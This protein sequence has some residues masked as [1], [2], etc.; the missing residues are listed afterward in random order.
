[1]SIPKV[2]IIIPVYKVEEYIE[3]C[4]RSLFSQTLDELEYIF[5]DD[6]GNDNSFNVIDKIIDEFPHR[7]SQVRIIRNEVNRGVGQTRRH[8][9]DVASGEY[10]IHCD[11]DDRVD[12]DMYQTLYEKAKLNDADVCICDY[13]VDNSAGETVV[14]QNA[15]SDKKALFH[16]L[17][18]ETL[19]AALWNKMVRSDLAKRFPIETGIN[20]W[21]DLSV[22][23]LILL[24]ANRIAKV[25]RP[26][27]HYNMA[28]SGSVSH[29]DYAKNVVSSVNAVNSLI[30]NMRKHNLIDIV[31]PIDLYRLQWSA[32][33]GLILD[34]TKDNIRR[35]QETFP[36]SNSHFRQLDISPNFKFLTWL[37]IHN[38]VLLL[39]LY[40]KVKSLRK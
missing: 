1:M 40:K 14:L 24:S 38:Q 9:I 17:S 3:K 7:R 29:I 10:I 28:N 39:K 27:Y 6:C 2:S 8:G 4:A 22:M 26:L 21:E 16:Q 23:P 19:H 37:A 12:S 13:Y 30:K 25:D 18:S 34:P 11:P 15:E 36:E 35:W 31:N 20:L 33:K 32:K 5:I